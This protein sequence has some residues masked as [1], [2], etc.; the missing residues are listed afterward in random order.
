MKEEDEKER[1]FK[2]QDRRRFSAE[3][4]AK[5]EAEDVP[6]KPAA[7]KPATIIGAEA[8]SHAG[9]HIDAGAGAAAAN[10]QPS[11]NQSPEPEI[12]FATFLVGLSSEALGALGELPDPASGQPRRDLQAAQQLIDIIGMLRDKTRGNL[13]A[14]EQSLID[15]VLFDLRMKYVELAR[16]SAH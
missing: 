14:T 7:E 2:V 12:T 15:A 3:G 13:D 9:E 5:S 11:R 16:Q 6:E 10:P 1:G 4:E 8:G